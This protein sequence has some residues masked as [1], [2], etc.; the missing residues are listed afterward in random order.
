MKMRKINLRSNRWQVAGG[1]VYRL[2]TDFVGHRCNEFTVH[3][4][5]NRER[6]PKETQD[7]TVKIAALLNA[8]DLS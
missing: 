6:T 4:S 2:F 5:S 3:V 8:A 1:L 7:L